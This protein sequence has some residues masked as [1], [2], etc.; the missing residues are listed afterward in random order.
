MAGITLEIAEARLTAWLAA[1]EALTVRGV[2]SYRV[3]TGTT[4]RE[5]TSYDLPEIRKQIDYWNAW[6][7]RL[8]RTGGGI[9]IKEVIPRG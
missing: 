9:R 5:V 4:D 8:G 6:A 7:Q 2:K 1:D 3:N